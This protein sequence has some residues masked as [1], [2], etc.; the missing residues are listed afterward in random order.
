MKH[1]FKMLSVV[2]VLVALFSASA[3]FKKPPREGE[4]TIGILQFASHPAL[5]AAKEGFKKALTEAFG[6]DVTFIEKNAQGSV[7]Q[8][9][10][11]AQGFN[12]DASLNGILAIATPA[13][14]AAA[15]IEKERP[16]FVTAVTDPV[17]AG[18]TKDENVCGSTDMIDVAQ[19]IALL[20]ALVPQV[21]T[22]AILFNQS[23]IN[24]TIVAAK[25]E[26]LLNKADLV[27][28]KI[29]VAQEADLIVGVEQA[30]RSADAIMTPIDNSVANAI[31]IVARKA[32][33]ARKPLIVAD[34]MLVSQGA[35]AAAGVSYAQTGEE[36]GRVA[37]RV[38]MHNEKPKAIGF[39][40][41]PT[42]KIAINKDTLEK[43]ALTIPEA[44]ANTAEIVSNNH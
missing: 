12:A 15:A 3:F 17:A 31:S 41:T 11:I 26:E 19:E 1:L 8:A 24:A 35:L 33:E 4:V 18:L 22:V 30:A 32:L 5:D 28:V 6:R 44:L 37:V 23:E 25:L 36:A 27:V 29:A 16:L 34:P 43:L 9:H 14:Q 42:T 38:L 10:L 21:K 7:S 13:A 2:G 20:K 40:T 39:V